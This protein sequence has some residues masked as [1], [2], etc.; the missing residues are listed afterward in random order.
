MQEKKVRDKLMNSKL[1][2]IAGLSSAL[3][4]GGIADALAQDLDCVPRS[5]VQCVSTPECTSGLPEAFEVPTAI[6]VN[7]K[8]KTIAANDI[9]GEIGNVYTDEPFIMADGRIPDSDRLWSL[10][11]NEETQ[12]FTTTIAGEDEAFVLFGV[13]LPR[14]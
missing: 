14:G 4:F 6:R 11:Y 8:E 5:I 1:G 13:C 2:I 9:Q 12:R 7:F 3:F 10:S